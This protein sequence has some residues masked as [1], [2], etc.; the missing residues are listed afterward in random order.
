MPPSGPSDKPDRARYWVG[1]IFS[2]TCFLALAL[3]T[4]AY[5]RGYPPLKRLDARF[6]NEVIPVL[7]TFLLLFL[8]AALVSLS[9]LGLSRLHLLFKQPPLETPFQGITL[10]EA[11]WRIL[12]P[13]TAHRL[14]SSAIRSTHNA[15]FRLSLLAPFLTFLIAL[16]F[17][18]H[19]LA[20]LIAL[21][22]L[23]FCTAAEIYLTCVAI[24]RREEP[25]RT[26]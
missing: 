19:R 25:A 9:F 2:F 15:L 23:T 4:A 26:D 7:L 1:F 11:G 16:P 18:S 20:F 24:R 22:P 13:S 8:F 17:V 14:S 5:L 6:P 10:K 12:L 3:L 21:V